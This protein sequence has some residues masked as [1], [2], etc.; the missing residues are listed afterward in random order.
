M[1]F[2]EDN[3]DLRFYV[4][5]AIPWNEIFEAMAYRG[6][7]RAF[8]NV[9]EASEF[10]RQVAGTLGELAAKELAPRVARID[11]EGARLENGEVTD[12]PELVKAFEAFRAADLHR[13][14]LP[15]ELGGLE[16]PLIVYFLGGEMIARADVS[17]MTHYSFHGG[18]GLAMVA[19]SIQEGTTEFREGGGFVTTRFRGYVDEIARGAA[20]GSMDITEPNAGSDMAQL[21]TKAEQDADGT[22]RIT[23]Q[24]IFITSGH[25]KYHFVVARTEEAARADDPFAGLGGL[26]MFLA[27]AYDD[28]PNGQRQRHVVIERLEEKLGHHGSATCALRFESTPAELIGKRG[29]GFRY[30]LMLMNNARV[31]V[32]FEGIGLAEAA[33]RMARAYAEERRTMGKPIARHEM[34]AD[35]LDEMEI[36]ILALRALAVTA[37]VHEELGQKREVMERHGGLEGAARAELAKK[38]RHHKRAA[39]RLTPLL[40]YAATEKAVEIARRNMQIHGGVGYTREYGAE[41]LM[42]DALVMPVYEGTSQIQALMAMKDTLTGIMKRPRAFAR[43]IAEARLAQMTSRDPLERRVAKLASISLSAQ[44]FLLARTAKDKLK[45]LSDAPVSTWA[46][47]LTKD[48]DPKRDFALAMLHA[49]RLIRILADEAMAEIL[50][51]QS[52]KFPERRELCERWLERAE[53]RSRMLHEEITTTGDRLLAKLAKE[54]ASAASTLKDAAE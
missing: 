47:A 14:C 26:S 44:Q 33:M 8:A 21:R 31:G 9:D 43:K 38:V 2:F 12:S 35:Y 24:K 52:K 36:D 46:R 13:M 34:I 22:W 1:S 48:W 25:G 11:R 54:S 5:R 7:E 3:A 40:K 17:A 42:R 32:G 4:E 18:M 41:K 15:A 51:E 27:K 19:Y 28:L 50:F 10:Y 49:E 6:R 16:V 23:G 20:W 39:R 30:M 29:E 37:A 53:I 45:S